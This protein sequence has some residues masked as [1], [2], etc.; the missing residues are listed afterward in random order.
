[1]RHFGFASLVVALSLAGPAPSQTTCAL[2]RDINRTGGTGRSSSP[3]GG[4]VLNGWWYFAARTCSY[5]IELWR[6]D[7]TTVQLVRDIDPGPRS[8]VPENFL[9]CGGHVYFTA[10]T[11]ANGNELWRTDGTRSGTVL[12]RDIAP[13]W[14]NGICHQL[15]RCGIGAS[16]CLGGRMQL[17]GRGAHCG[18]RPYWWQER[19]SPPRHRARQGRARLL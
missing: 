2:V 18:A 6:T 14:S 8:S 10:S 17:C 5:G 13:V 16:D 7:G 11:A 1:M 4:A 9:T 12:V 15:Q 19:L 3:S